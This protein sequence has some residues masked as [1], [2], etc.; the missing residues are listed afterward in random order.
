[1]RERAYGIVKW[2]FLISSFVFYGT[3]LCFISVTLISKAMGYTASCNSNTHSMEPTVDFTSLSFFDENYPFD[4]IVVG[5]IISFTNP[6][7]IEMTAPNGSTAY[8]YSFGN[9]DPDMQVSHRVISIEYDDAGKYFVTKG[10]NNDGQDLGRVHEKYYDGKL[11]WTVKYLG[12][13]FY[14]FFVMHG[15]TISLIATIISFSFLPLIDNE[16]TMDALSRLLYKLKR[17]NEDDINTA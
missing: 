10:D 17:Q 1:M 4:D 8:G 6:P 9:D 2:I 11:I 16:R 3:T 12:L 13:P 14:F 7:A 5:D 15:N